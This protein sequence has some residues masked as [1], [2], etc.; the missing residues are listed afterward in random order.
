MESICTKFHAF[1]KIRSIDPVF[2][3]Y[4]P[5]YLVNDTSRKKF[6][7]VDWFR[8][9]VANGDIVKLFKKMLLFPRIPSYCTQCK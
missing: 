1:I 3:S 8:K 7:I 9:C 5:H 4:S 6:S 2:Y